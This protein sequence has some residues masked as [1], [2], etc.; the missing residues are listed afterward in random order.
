M[1]GARVGVLVDPRD[2]RVLGAALGHGVV[3]SALLI[4]TVNPQISLPLRAFAICALALGVVWGCNTV[5]HLHLHNPLFR[6]HSVNLAF[7][8]YLTLL[9]GVPQHHWKARHLAHHFPARRHNNVRTPAPWLEIAALALGLTALGALVPATLLLTW[10]P[11]LALGLGL[12]ALQGHGEHAASAAGVDHRGRLH[13]LLWF[14]DGFHAAHHRAPTARWTTVAAHAL[15]EDVVSPTPPIRRGLGALLN[16]L[17]GAALDRLERL[18]FSSSLVRRLLLVSHDRA[19][20]ELLGQLDTTRL[21]EVVVVGGGL[22]PR[23][24][25]LLLRRL[26][27]A[28]IT[29]V[30]AAAEHLE[31]ARR[32]LDATVAPAVRA[33]VGTTVGLFDPAAPIDCDLLVVP[34]GLR[35]DRAR[36][37]TKPPAPAV[38]VHD[39]L[40]R[41]RGTASVRVALLL[42][43]RLNL[44]LARGV[45]APPASDPSLSAPGQSRLN[46]SPPSPIPWTSSPLPVPCSRPTCSNASDGATS[47]LS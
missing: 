38:L 41:R 47:R 20:G 34:L 7:G 24:A 9:L 18:A 42:G 35:G 19:L 32:W 46:A 33:R 27:H 29:L 40:W 5:S 44:V 17:Q 12:C 15:P 2:R 31:Q 28:R 21:H 4:A 23:T 13:N 25:L 45:H 10:L 39:W 43:K 26:P 30:D 16:H 3:A 6:S 36:L 14:N 37:Y 11:G 8:V 1:S 22:F